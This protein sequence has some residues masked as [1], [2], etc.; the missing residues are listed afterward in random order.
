[1]PAT[2]VLLAFR[3]EEK[4][5]PGFF[6]HLRE[7]VS[8]FIVL[9]DNST[10]RSAEVAASQPNTTLLTR[11]NSE[12][13]P[14]HFFEVDNRRLLLEVARARGAEWAL[15]CDADERVEKR[16]LDQL[17]A[18]TGGPKVAYGLRVRDLWDSRDQYRVDGF[19]GDKA[20][21]VF[22]PL[23]PFGEYY[24]SH[25]LHTRWPPPNVRCEDENILDLNLYH[26]IS[27]RRADRLARLRKFKSIDPEGAHQRRI[28][29]DYLVDESGLKL[30]KITPDRDFQLVVE[31]APL[32]A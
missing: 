14:A 16:F 13:T 1:M 20:K 19:W 32:F 23:L 15:C 6:A 31:D 9:D 4:Y 24:P 22:F 26:L 30:E 12:P 18:L 3:N 2:V 29:Y 21:F 27:L 10:D 8:E 25:A 28:G 11:R 17:E 5:L 7:R